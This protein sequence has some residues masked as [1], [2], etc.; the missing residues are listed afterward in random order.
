MSMNKQ[1]KVTFNVTATVSDAGEEE[2]LEAL[3]GMAKEPARGKYF[4]NILITALTYGPEG[5]LA[6]VV[7]QGLRG[8]IKEMSREVID[9]NGD[10][11]RMKFSPARVEVI[12]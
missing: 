9:A 7:K 4:D 10:P 6:Q 2:F 12:R 3:M 5:A 8:S 1:F 11:I